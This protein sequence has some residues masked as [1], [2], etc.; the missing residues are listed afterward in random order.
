MFS[1]R[2]KSLLRIFLFF[3]PL[4]LMVHTVAASA[5][6]YEV[7]TFTLF[8]IRQRAYTLENQKSEFLFYEYIDLSMQDIGREGLSFRAYGWGRGSSDLAFGEQ[9][10][11]GALS[12]AVLSYRPQKLDA[13]FEI[14]RIFSYAGS[15]FEQFD[16]FSLSG[17][18]APAVEMSV[19]GGDPVNYTPFSKG[20]GDLIYGARISTFVR[21]F[22]GIGIHYL[23]ENE[24]GNPFR[25]ES[26][27][28]LWL[29]PAKFVDFTGHVFYNN[30]TDN[31]SNYRALL[32]LQ[33][34]KK[35]NI[36]AELSKFIYSDFFFATPL[37]VF[38]FPEGEEVQ[39][40]K[41]AVDFP[42]TEHFSLNVNYQ[43]FDFKESDPADRYS[44]EAR[45]AFGQEGS[46][47]G[48]S[49][50]R[51]DGMEIA[52]QYDEIQSY[53]FFQKKKFE[54]SLYFV[55]TSY[56]ESLFDVKNAYQLLASS[57]WRISDHAVISADVQY[58][59]NPQYKSDLTGMIRLKYDF[60][61]KE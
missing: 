27:I 59:R 37:S 10:E 16:G 3:I 35:M 31:I 12:Y 18:L 14:G 48:I 50:N 17:R 60:G 5:A 13:S 57:G 21:G 26:G 33:P 56:D 38:H 53:L 25:E 40:L 8:N 19:F 20:R 51:M 32:L 6:D 23:K 34:H 28:D 30:I 45:Y 36:S 15:S 43:S 4:L 9:K 58:E 44:I 24:K 39:K 52:K 1:I 61:K 2:A 11:N 47:A 29:K 42:L 7:S 22:F 46:C 54:G 49:L 55:G 41:T